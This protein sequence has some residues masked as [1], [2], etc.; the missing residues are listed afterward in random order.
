M[1]EGIL[2]KEPVHIH[3]WIQFLQHNAQ[4]RLER[5]GDY[6]D[7]EHATLLHMPLQPNPQNQEAKHWL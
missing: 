6:L 1:L 3:H 2:N 7:A 5:N 4:K